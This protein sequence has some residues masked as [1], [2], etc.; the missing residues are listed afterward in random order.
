MF[1]IIEKC[2]NKIKGTVLVI[3]EW[4]YALISRLEAGYKV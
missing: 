2:E 1:C 4:T 3:K